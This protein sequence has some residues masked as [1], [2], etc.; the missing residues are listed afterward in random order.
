MHKD[1]NAVKGGAE[2]M[3]EWWEKSGE[4]PPVELGIRKRGEAL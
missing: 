4:T 1:L 3:S 2:Q